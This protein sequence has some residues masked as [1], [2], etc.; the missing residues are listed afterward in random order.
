MSNGT[1]TQTEVTEQFKTNVGGLLVGVNIQAMSVFQ[2]FGLASLVTTAY[3]R[4]HRNSDAKWIKSLIM[5]VWSLCG[6][7]TA[8]DFYSTY[9]FLVV[10]LTIPNKQIWA[11]WSLSLLISIVATV[12]TVV[13]LLLLHRLARFHQR[14]GDLSI[15]LVSVIVL[16]ALLS[17]V[18]IGEYT[19]KR[20]GGIG[21]TVR[22]LL[23]N[24]RAVGRLKAIFDA[25]LVCAIAADVCFVFVQ[26]YSLHRSRS[27]FRR[28]DSVI[29]LLIL[30]TMS[31]G[32]IPTT[33]AMATLISMF[34]EPQALLYASLY[35]QVGNLYLITLVASLNHRQFVLRRIAR[36]L[37]LNYSALGRLSNPRGD[38]LPTRLTIAVNVPQLRYADAPNATDS[39]EGPSQP[40]RQCAASTKEPLDK[41]PRT[42]PTPLQGRERRDAFECDRLHETIVLETRNRDDHRHDE[43]PG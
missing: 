16:V 9:Y 10:T 36:P 12:S 19:A 6:F 37:E 15:G 8:I 20:S 30:Y 24:D 11:P 34:V 33:L 17:L 5:I 38:T 1:N 25:L 18:G 13:R 2:V 26:S 21:I 31:T 14:K 27:G 42:D 41:S 28:T 39:K 43:P 35:M 7:S 22:L 29:N 32:L 40:S 3:F 23:P 4:Q